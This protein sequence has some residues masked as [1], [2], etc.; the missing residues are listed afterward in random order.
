[1]QLNATNRT[2]RPRGRILV[3]ITL[4]AILLYQWQT[5]PALSPVPRF[6]GTPEAVAAVSLPRQIDR[7]AFAGLLARDPLAALRQARENHLRNVR[8]YHCTFV[9]QELLFDGMS[10]EQVIDVKFQQEP[11]SIVMSWIRN[12]GKAVRVI[13]VAG[14]WV[15]AGAAKAEEREL[16]LCQPG[17][18]AA[19]F[20]KSVKQPIRGP[21]AHEASRR[22]IDDFGF[23]KALDMM[24]EFSGL[25]A[26][27]GELK[28]VFAG[29][30][31]F[32]GRPTWVLHRWV[33]YDGPKSRYPDAAAVYHIDQEW[34]VPVAIQ[35]Y[36]DAERKHLLGRYEY[37]DVKLNVGLAHGDFA[38]ETYG[39]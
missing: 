14:R 28:L 29:A 18:I 16:A 30:S 15:D 8:D 25:A 21:R 35:S 19:M 33:P 23:A 3:G 24:I 11:Y 39:M 27:R 22:F 2:R 36:G 26:S 12:P 20:V 13:Y 31:E 1:M 37:R 34:L 4:A 9:K 17:A 10:K 7:R 6:H 5:S 38:P 32:D